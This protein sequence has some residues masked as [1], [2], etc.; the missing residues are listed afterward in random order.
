VSEP[1]S[2]ESLATAVQNAVIEKVAILCA[3]GEMDHASLRRLIA[4]VLDE[5]IDE[6]IAGSCAMSGNGPLFG[7][8]HPAGAR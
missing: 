4:T 7:D 1:S 8:H 5:F 6:R 2:P 3:R